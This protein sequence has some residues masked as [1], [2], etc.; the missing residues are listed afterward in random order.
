M[1]RD[2]A[3]RLC[4]CGHRFDVHAAETPDGFTDCQSPDCACDRFEPAVLPRRR[5][6]CPLCGGFLRSK[7]GPRFSCSKCGAVFD[8]GKG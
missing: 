7:R 8:A 4:I 5:Q 6:Q 2:D 3:A 1:S